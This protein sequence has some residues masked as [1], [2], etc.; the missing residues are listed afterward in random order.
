[1]EIDPEATHKDRKDKDDYRDQIV[2]YDV[3]RVYDKAYNY[4]SW[5]ESII[6]RDDEEILKNFPAKLEEDDNFP[7]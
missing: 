5:F 7:F 2:D 1:M 3:V 4:I 6:D